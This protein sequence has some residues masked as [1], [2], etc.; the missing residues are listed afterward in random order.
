MKETS[1]KGK[2]MAKKRSIVTET[3]I[4]QFNW[5]I[6]K[7]RFAIS[8]IFRLKLRGRVI[9]QRKKNIAN[10]IRL[11]VFASVLQSVFCVLASKTD[12]ASKTESL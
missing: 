1:L 4:Q 5:R 9:Y 12:V 10:E 3:R 11:S 7:Q 8:R 2:T 6:L